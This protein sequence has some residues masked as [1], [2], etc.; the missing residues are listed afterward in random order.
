MIDPS[1]ES[2]VRNLSIIFDNVEGVGVVPICISKD[3]DM[4][5]RLSQVGEVLFVSSRV[6]GQRLMY[7]L[8]V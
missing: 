2:S 3:K 4:Y 8:W 5:I 7:N 1:I 6:R